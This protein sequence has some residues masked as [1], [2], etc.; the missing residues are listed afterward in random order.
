[1]VNG[2]Y[3]GLAYC[4]PDGTFALIHG[5]DELP[6]GR[7]ESDCH[8]ITAMEL[9]YCALYNVAHSYPVFVTRYP[10][11]GVGSI[12]PSYVYL[13]STVK[14]DERIELNPDTWEPYPDNRTAF[15]FPRTDSS[16]FNS[17][18]PHASRIGRLGADFDGD[19]CSA[20]IVYSDDAL[21]EVKDYFKSPHAYVGTDG[22]FI[23]DTNIDTVK[24]VLRNTTGRKKY[25]D[26]PT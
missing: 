18:S 26:L 15:Q 2:C 24:F 4:G 17:L 10:I 23:N 9:L 12:Y 20:N 13:K 11:T 19:T 25:T 5:I 6:E 21:K 7:N 1:M 14:F 3:L 22:K 16:S 8:P